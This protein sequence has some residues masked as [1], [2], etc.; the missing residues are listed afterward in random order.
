MAA[1]VIAPFIIG[2]LPMFMGVLLPLLGAADPPVPLGAA[3]V[4]LVGCV[5]ALA[6]ALPAVPPVLVPVPAVA[7]VLLLLVL[8]LVESP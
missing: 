4:L 7:V 5:L 8:P 3:G 1:G 2:A 6:P